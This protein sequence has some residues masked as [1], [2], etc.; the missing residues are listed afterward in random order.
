MAPYF[1]NCDLL[2][3]ADCVAYASGDFHREHMKGRSI[4]IACPK[5]DSDQEEYVS[6]LTTMIDQ[7]NINTISVMIMEVPCC[8]GLLQMAMAAVQQAKRKVPVK[9]IKMSL[10]GELQ[11]ERWF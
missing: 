8:G 5:L 4:A 10:H 1:R 7:A 3:A 6:K 11:A 2:L 9:M